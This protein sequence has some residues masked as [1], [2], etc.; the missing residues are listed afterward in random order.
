MGKERIIADM[1]EV[2]KQAAKFILE[3]KEVEETRQK[4]RFNYVTQ[5]DVRVQEW[6]R[7][8]LQEKYQD[9]GFLG[10]E[11]R[12]HVLNQ[13]KMWILDPIDGTT[14]YMH[15]YHSS[16]ISLA[17]VEK[18]E[19]LAGVVYQPYTQEMFWAVKDEGACLNET[20][21]QVSGIETLEES[22]IA[23]GTS[24]YDKEDAE[25]N[26]KTFHK[27]F[28]QCMDI[29]RSGSAAL[30]LVWVAC[31]RCEAYLEK[32]LKVWDY[33]AGMLI[34]KEAGGSIT[35]YSGKELS[36][37]LGSDVIA[38]NGKIGGLVQAICGS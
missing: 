33:A 8:Q 24:P 22:L 37:T 18:G 11:Q 35:D 14:N 19:V 1:R 4:G 34:L 5:V 20:S 3:R 38:S 6:I 9:V 16:A 27:I 23:I 26:F 15:D 31:G 29:R 17:Y 2:V 21:I 30:D 10:E 28:M 32:G 13:E 36:L 12:E 7:T 25:Q